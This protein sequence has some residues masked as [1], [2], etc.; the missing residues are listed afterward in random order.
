MRASWHIG[1]GVQSLIFLAKPARC[2]FYR[3]LQ[4]ARDFTFI[5]VYYYSSYP[6]STQQDNF[7]DSRQP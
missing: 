5:F 1:P 7:G 6:H 2:T 4:R 3:M